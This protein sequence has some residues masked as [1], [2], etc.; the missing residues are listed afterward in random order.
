[1]QNYYDY[2]PVAERHRD[3]GI[4]A[5]SFGQVNVPAHAS[6]PPALHP[7]NHALSWTRGRILKEH[8]L[9]FISRGS[10]HFECEGRGCRLVKKGTLLLLFPGVWHR[11]RPEPATGWTEHWIELQGEQMKRLTSLGLIKAERPVHAIGLVPEVLAGFATAGQLARSKPPGFQ[12]RIGLLGLQI[13]TCVIFGSATGITSTRMDRSVQE[14]LR[15]LGANFEDGLSPAKVAGKL[16]FSYSYFRRSFKAH[17]GFSPKQYRLEVRT[18]HACN[19]LRDGER[20]IKEVAERLGYDSPYH[21]SGDFKKRTGVSP[22]AWRRGQRRDGG[23][24]VE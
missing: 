1:M 18:R 10:G 22:S 15:M 12:V 19:L 21:L 6:Y 11:Y 16:H 7:E 23:G 13:L 8:Q 5:T 3:W 20:S 14:A 9:V 2:F 24:G 4:Y 17:T